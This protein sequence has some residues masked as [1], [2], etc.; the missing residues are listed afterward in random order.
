MYSYQVT[1][2]QIL[3]IKNIHLLNVMSYNLKKDKKD[4]S[5]KIETGIG[6]ITDTILNN[7]LDKLNSDGFKTK[8]IESIYQPALDIILAKFKPYLYLLASLYLIII[9]LLII[10][11]YLLIRR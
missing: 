10:E 5:P 11:L 8:L 9:F 3:H 1:N 6:P 4:N 7:C 2:R